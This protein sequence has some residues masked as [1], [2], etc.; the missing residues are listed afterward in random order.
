[1]IAH[2]GVNLTKNARARDGKQLDAFDLVITTYALT[3]KYE[4]LKSHS[5]NYVIL[6]EAQA[7]KNPGTKQARAI[8]TLTSRNRIIMTGTPI[9]NRGGRL[10][11]LSR[12][13]AGFVTP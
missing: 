6:D 8:K 11:R 9:E 2:P 1:L 7:I 12:S 4:W 5:W 10:V 3:Q 13:K